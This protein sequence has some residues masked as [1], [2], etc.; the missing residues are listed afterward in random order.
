M[1]GIGGNGDGDEAGA[2]DGKTGDNPRP[3][4][5]FPTEAAFDLFDVAAAVLHGDDDSGALL[6][7]SNVPEGAGGVIGL[8][9][10]EEVIVASV[11]PAEFA[12]H[13][14]VF[15]WGDVFSQ[16]TGYSKTGFAQ[17]FEKA[18]SQKKI[19]TMT[20]GGEHAT[21]GLAQGTCAENKKIHKSIRLSYTE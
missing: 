4:S 1:D 17:P 21:Q 15:L 19:D 14:T 2:G 5:S 8:G 3:E 7:G 13:A 20:V 9:G 18:R 11:G 6:E 16:D 12:E 10:Q